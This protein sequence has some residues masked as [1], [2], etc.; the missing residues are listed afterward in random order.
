MIMKNRNISWR[1]LPFIFLLG[2]SKEDGQPTKDFVALYGGT[3]FKGTVEGVRLA[4]GSETTVFE[5]TEL[6][7]NNLNL[8]YNE[9]AQEDLNEDGENESIVAE[10]SIY[11]TK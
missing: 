11:L 4:S 7:A 10:I 3:P 6:T 8:S 2:C 5:V 9:E 1:L